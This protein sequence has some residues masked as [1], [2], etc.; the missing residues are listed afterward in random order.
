ML[1][2][3]EQLRS[4][5]RAIHALTIN[6]EGEEVFL[7][8]TAAESIFYLARIANPD[9]TTSAA[10]QTLYWQLKYKHLRARTSSILGDLE[11]NDKDADNTGR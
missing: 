4:R 10:E 1:K 7:G 3:N 9:G 11:S 6:A 2:L 8:L 5:L